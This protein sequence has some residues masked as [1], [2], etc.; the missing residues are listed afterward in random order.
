PGLAPYAVAS[1]GLALVL[2]L[3]AR[4][5]GARRSAAYPT[6]E[7]IPTLGPPTPPPTATDP[8]LAGC[9]VEVDAPHPIGAVMV[10]I[11]EGLEHGC[12]RLLGSHP[13]PGDPGG[14][15]WPPGR[16]AGMILEAVDPDWALAVARQC[17]ERARRDLGDPGRW[18]DA[19]VAELDEPRSDL[20]SLG[21]VFA[22]HEAA[23]WVDSRPLDA[24]IA[25]FRPRPDWLTRY[26]EQAV[27]PFWWTSAQDHDLDSGVVALDEAAWRLVA[28]DD[29]E[30]PHRFLLVAWPMAAT[31]VL[32]RIV[33]GIPPGSLQSL[34]RE[35]AMVE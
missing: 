13:A 34:A 9:E 8:V 27:V 26:F 24:L 17:A 19:L 29:R 18:T 25:S 21:R 7:P 32:V 31:A 35:G 6:P 4:R 5:R 3:L 20:R 30:G 10:R 33:Q 11:L 16:P 2:A 14:P 22:R 15:T 28:T 12:D 23:R 1:H